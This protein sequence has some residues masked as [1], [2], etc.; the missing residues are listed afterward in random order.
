MAERMHRDNSR[1]SPRTPSPEPGEPPME[2]SPVRGTGLQ[3]SNAVRKI[4]TDMV[5]RRREAL[6][7]ER[8]T[9]SSPPSSYETQHYLRRPFS[10]ERPG[11]S[12][13]EAIPDSGPNTPQQLKALHK[14]MEREAVRRF[15]AEDN[16][17][18]E[19]DV[20]SEADTIVES[21][22]TDPNGNPSDG[23]SDTDR[24][25][26]MTQFA[27]E[28]HISKPGPARFYTQYNNAGRTAA[29]RGA[30]VHAASVA[31]AAADAPSN[32]SSGTVQGDEDENEKPLICR[33]PRFPID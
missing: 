11:T 18:S 31:A 4:G 22:D 10:F 19:V 16:G 2:T 30:R 13:V 25:E 29:Q 26:A 33:K 7:N 21:E 14:S 3:R 27:E 32:A 8:S 5:Q 15:L 23:S 9:S 1:R 6:S 24:S 12:M 28:V 20:D 17:G